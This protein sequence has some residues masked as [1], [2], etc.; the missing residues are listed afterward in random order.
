MYILGALQVYAII[1][2][3]RK[4]PIILF[5]HGVSDHPDLD[6]EG[7]SFS[8]KL[9]TKQIKYISSHFEVISMCEFEKRLKDNSFSNREAVITFDDGYKNNLTIAAPILK[10]Y[11]LPFTVFVSAHNIDAQE[12]FYISVPRLIIVGGELSKV[13][14]PSVGYVRQL[15]NK[16]ER[17]ACAREIEY[18]IK[19]LPHE[20]AK[21]ISRE[22][23]DYYGEDRFAVLCQKYDN[24]ELLTWDDCRKLIDEYECTI[25]SHSFD[26][27]ICHDTQEQEIVDF[28]LAESKKLIEAKLLLQCKY[29]AYP[30]GNY[31][32]QSNSKVSHLYNLG[33]STKDIGIYR[34]DTSFAS[35]GRIG[36]PC[37]LRE[38]KFLL[39]KFSLFN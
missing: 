4:S 30:N 24:G 9:F 38:L 12:R 39:A 11:N 15:Q 25:G 14:I 19:Y 18:S 7:E 28:Q 29:F 2:H 35:I 16:H 36:V 3:F 1:L 5:W 6:V 10:K 20:K 26:H 34:Q 27:C 23:I 13:E 37:S 33:F 22:L 32:S 21:K 17:I 8:V 31:T